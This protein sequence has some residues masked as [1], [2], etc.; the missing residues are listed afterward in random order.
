MGGFAAVAVALMSFSGTASK[1][2]LRSNSTSNDRGP[3]PA[4][5][6]P[7]PYRI[8]FELDSAGLVSEAF[9]S[10]DNPT[11][12]F[13]DTIGNDLQV[14]D[15]GDQGN[16]QALGVFGDDPSALFMLF[17]VPT[18]KVSLTFG[19]DDPGFAQPGDTATLIVY[20]NL[21]RIATRHVVM[22]LND[23][24][25]QVITYTGPAIDKARFVY[26]RAG[27]PINL[28][29]IVDDINLAPICTIGGNG[30]GNNLRGT[31]HSDGL[32]GFGGADNL[33]SR[34]GNDIVFG[35]PGGDTLNG[36][37][38]NDLLGGG[39]GND[40]VKVADRVSGNDIAYGGPGNDVCEID[41]GDTA[42][43]DCETVVPVP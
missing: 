8:G 34:A 32:C 9:T 39:L 16:G 15:F 24:A 42:A 40:T 25:D 17:D 14:Q 4:V 31:T 36:G 21:K 35:G 28:I 27:T 23:L 3:S 7:D 10:K 38:G 19:N 33:D 41:E 5:S 37:D 30:A 12:H 2:A 29:E 26:D 11:V 43:A 1:A 18:T 20:R 6:T 13:V 22:N